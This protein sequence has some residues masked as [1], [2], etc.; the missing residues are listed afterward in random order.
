MC[1]GFFIFL[2]FFSIIF[3]LG[4]SKKDD[5][6]FDFDLVRENNLPLNAK[7]DKSLE[8]IS[9]LLSG[10]G[11]LYSVENII[12]FPAAVQSILYFSL[13]KTNQNLYIRIVYYEDKNLFKINSYIDF[14]IPIKNIDV[15][16]IEYNE[17][18]SS[19]HMGGKFGSLLINSKYNNPEAFKS[20]KTKFENNNLIVEDVVPLGL[21][22]IVIN[23]EVGRELKAPFVSFVKNFNAS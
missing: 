19:K 15:N 17:Y 23:P 7:A 20:R 14:E 4:C 6:F 16:N 11:T 2:L 22:S 5:Y 13:D 1:R 10:K 12:D 21:L 8:E 18:H 3:V 9:N